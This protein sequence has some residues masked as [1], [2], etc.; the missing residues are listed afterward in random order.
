MIVLHFVAD[1]RKRLG[2]LAREV[3]GSSDPQYR[4]R[5]Y[6]AWES[7][8]ENSLCQTVLRSVKP[9]DVTSMPLNAERLQSDPPA[10]VD[11]DG[12]VLS[13]AS[14]PTETETRHTTV[15]DADDGGSVTSVTDQQ[16]SETREVAETDSKDNDYA[17]A[18]KVSDTTV[19]EV[20]ERPVAESVPVTEY[21][22]M[23]IPS[24][25]YANLVTTSGRGFGRNCQS[26]WRSRQN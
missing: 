17:A 1:I 6:S 2:G 18:S 24:S 10:D 12:G 19:T 15:A 21:F 3:F 23:T 5:L 8:T 7:D 14:E 11:D 13:T 16:A 26:A 4:K 25:E 22:T 20:G 9:V